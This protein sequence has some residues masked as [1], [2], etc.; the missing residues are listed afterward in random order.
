MKYTRE[1]KSS[2]ERKEGPTL[3]SGDSKHQKKKE[4]GYQGLDAGSIDKKYWLNSFS[5]LRR[6]A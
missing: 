6:Q 1:T 3:T 5:P 4:L 2:E